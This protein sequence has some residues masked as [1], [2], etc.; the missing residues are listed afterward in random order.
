M[1]VYA[2][3]AEHYDRWT[4]TYPEIE[5]QWG[6]FGEN[7][8]TEGLHERNTC[9]GDRFRC[10]SAE[11]LVTAPR[12][13]CAKL[14]LRLG[15]PAAV[16]TMLELGT[17]GFYLSIAV[18]G[19]LEAGDTIERVHADPRRVTIADINGLYDGSL[20]DAEIAARAMRVEALPESWKDAIARRLDADR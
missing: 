8:T 1:A 13:P 12:R 19:R 2:F 7:L 16:K 10:G 15:D 17:S 4:P 18:E 6:A 11:L 20:A 14:A 9:V 3:P 5:A